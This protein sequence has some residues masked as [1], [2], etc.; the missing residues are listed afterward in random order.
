MSAVM[1]QW[2]TGYIN[3]RVD[4]VITPPHK[5]CKHSVHDDPNHSY[6]NFSSYNML[7]LKRCTTQ[8]T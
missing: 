4:F 1:D 8:V 3:D 5:L 7:R 2:L 6:I